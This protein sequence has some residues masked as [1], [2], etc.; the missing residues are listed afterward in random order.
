MRL[1]PKR[2]VRSAHR[3][4][5]E[6]GIVRSVRIA[7]VF[8]R[9]KKALAEFRSKKLEQMGKAEA[10]LDAAIAAMSEE[11]RRAET[12]LHYARERRD[13]VMPTLEALKESIET[14]RE[15]VESEREANLSEHDR[16]VAVSVRLD[17]RTREQ[18]ALRSTLT[19][20]SER[21]HHDTVK[22][23]AAIA[24]AKRVETKNLTAERSLERMESKL[25]NE[26][27]RD[28]KLLAAQSRELSVRNG[29]LDARERRLDADRKGLERS[30]KTLRIAR[31]QFI[32]E[33][34]HYG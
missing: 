28:K 26:V 10:D 34:S 31:E 4:E 13:A 2:E 5:E 24:E 21:V 9:E 20:L 33:K 8:N 27:D 1:L 6:R 19:A 18:E 3:E 30:Q 7:D 23:N 14:A 25:T 12:E 15:I 29:L 16:L 11:R 17:G 32:K 22:A